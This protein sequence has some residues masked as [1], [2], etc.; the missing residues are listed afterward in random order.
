M[1][2]LSRSAALA[3]IPSSSPALSLR[4]FSLAR[5]SL[6]SAHSAHSDHSHDHSHS[7]HPTDPN[8]D[9]SHIGHDSVYSRSE[10]FSS[11]FWPALVL[12]FAALLFLSRFDDWITKGGE[13]PHPISSIIG[14]T[15][16]SLS[17]IQ[18]IEQ[19]TKT[20]ADLFVARAKET[21]QWR[22]PEPVPISRLRAPEL[23]FK[24]RHGVA[25]PVGQDYEVVPRGTDSEVL[26]DIKSQYDDEERFAPTKPIFSLPDKHIIDVPWKL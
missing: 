21:A 25:V 13:K 16:D 23:V 1:L 18:V 10:S 7:H 12:S 15:A 26:P 17:S 2:R 8:A 20:Y 9:P 3:P 4:L 19:E 14:N 24:P 6:A 22:Q 5:H 11:P